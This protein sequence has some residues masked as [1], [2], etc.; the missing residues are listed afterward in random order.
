MAAVIPAGKAP[1][2]IPYQG[3]KRR[4]A[5]QILNL[6]GHRTFGTLYE[7]FAGSAAI[8]INAARRGL[9][10]RFMIGD[11]LAP[12]VELW[13]L[14]LRTPGQ[15]A[16]A[17]E[18]IW[19]AQLQDPATHYLTVRDEFN[20]EGG[21]ARLLYLLARCVKNSPRFN[22]T[23][24]FNQSPDHRR[25]GM[26]PGKMR[27]E[28]MGA[29]TLLQGRAEA[30]CLDFA[31]ALGAA[32]PRDLVYLDPPWEGTSTGTDKRYYA[33]LARDRLVEA[34]ESLDARA[35]PYLLSYDGR[36]G[37]KQY[38]EPLPESIGAVRLELEAG[39]S[40]QATLNGQAVKTVESL[41]VSRHVGDVALAPDQLDFFDAAA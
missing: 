35:V 4:L 5:D 12:L 27:R 6:V 21:S 24:Q 33:G 40:S 11:S 30:R 32:T 17:Y 26:N 3:S 38:G 34:L 9:A 7:P 23:G 36:H 31:E 1:H 25:K 29:H 16:D 41:Y 18:E 13:S 8:S 10:Q 15:L 28:I 22:A 20:A 39:R 37:D 2:P 14:I 19:N